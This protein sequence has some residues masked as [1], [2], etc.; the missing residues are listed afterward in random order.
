MNKVYTWVKFRNTLYKI[1]NIC[2]REQNNFN[3]LCVNVRH[4]PNETNLTYSIPHFKVKADQPYPGLNLQLLDDSP[5]ALTTMLAVRFLVVCHRV[6]GR[7]YMGIY[8]KYFHEYCFI[9][10]PTCGPHLDTMGGHVI[11]IH[12]FK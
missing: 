8:Y 5:Q 10:T 7:L 1:I 11:P 12:T 2:E 9:F 4:Y 3:I 6:I